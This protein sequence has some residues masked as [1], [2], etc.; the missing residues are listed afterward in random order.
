M[1][2]YTMN[3]QKKIL[4]WIKSI[5]Q[6]EDH[7]WNE[8]MNHVP[9]ICLPQGDLPAAHS[10]YIVHTQKQRTARGPLGV[11]H[12]CLWPLHWRLLDPP[13]WR[14]AKP[15][16]SL[17]PVPRQCRTICGIIQMGVSSHGKVAHPHVV[18]GTEVPQNLIYLTHMDRSVK[19]CQRTLFLT[20]YSAWKVFTKW[21]LWRKMDQSLVTNSSFYPSD[22]CS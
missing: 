9:W 14:V 5:G 4:G 12:R 1:Q 8:W 13:W 19:I 10:R 7:E 18:Y 11:Y 17:T 21:L 16:V 15:L 22:T 20:R 2:Q 6:T 3:T